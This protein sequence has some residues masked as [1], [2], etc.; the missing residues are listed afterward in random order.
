MKKITFLLLLAGSVIFIAGCSGEAEECGTSPAE[1]TAG[2]SHSGFDTK[3]ALIEHL[4]N[5]FD[6]RDGN[7]VLE[8]FSPE[9]LQHGIEICGSRE[10]LAAIWQNFSEQFPESDPQDKAEEVASTLELLDDIMVQIDGKWY[11][12][13]YEEVF[14]ELFIKYTA[15]RF[16]EAARSHN[17]DIIWG[18]LSP[19]CRNRAIDR[20]RFEA[21]AIAALRY[22]LERE[23]TASESG[24]GNN[25]PD[26]FLSGKGVRF[27]V[28]DGKCEAEIACLMDFI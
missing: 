11:L 24:A 2:V 19:E 22:W 12:T 23:F 1:T 13:R 5:A 15:G 9:T 18:M 16:L 8:V 6:R 26:I 3:E 7:A 20:Y 14:E 25:D 27:R 10:N 4:L 21:N 28:A 17:S